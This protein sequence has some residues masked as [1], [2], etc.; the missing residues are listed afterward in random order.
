M[1]SSKPLRIP[2]FHFSR[3]GPGTTAFSPPKIRGASEPMHASGKRGSL[4][5][6]DAQRTRPGRWRPSA[7]CSNP[8]CSDC[9]PKRLPLHGVSDLKSA[10]SGHEMP[11]AC[12]MN[13]WRA[14][15]R[16]S[17][18][19]SLLRVCLACGIT[20][21][22]FWV[23]HQFLGQRVG[24][25]VTSSVELLAGLLTADY[26]V[27]YS[28]VFALI[29]PAPRFVTLTASLAKVCDPNRLKPPT[30]LLVR[31]PDSFLCENLILANLGLV[32]LYWMLVVDQFWTGMW[33]KRYLPWVLLVVAM[34]TGLIGE[35]LVGDLATLLL[36]VVPLIWNACM[37]GCL[38]YDVVMGKVGTEL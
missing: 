11:R 4:R 30:F 12:H 13:E 27:R 10:M 17:F 35:F 38:V 23:H 34:T 18:Y 3:G 8:R 9:E 24:K 7:C 5:N 2:P 26:P 36:G 1:S 16:P 37:I 19:P 15:S 20:S 28:Q 32:M 33:R 6:S 14:P 31:F 22:Q 21:I 29:R 25:S